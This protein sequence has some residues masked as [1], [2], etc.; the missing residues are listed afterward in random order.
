MTAT[1]TLPLFDAGVNLLD[2]SYVDCLE[3]IISR[4]C[5]NG[6]R[7]MLCISS[8]LT[9]SEQALGLL[10]QYQMPIFAT[11]GVHPHHAK[12]VSQGWQSQLQD[13]LQQPQVKAIGETGLDF[14]RNYSPPEQQVRV[15]EGQ[16]EIAT[17]SHKPLYL[18]ERDAHSQLFEM[19]RT[20]RDHLSG[21][22]LHCFTGDKKALYRYLDL[23]LYIGI[24]GW[25]CDERRGK[26][27]LKLVKDIP[28]DRLILETDAPYL[29]P[30]TLTPKPKSRRNEP[31]F[32]VEIC[33][34]LALTLDQD[35]QQLAA[36][37]SDNACRLFQLQLPS[38][39]QSKDSK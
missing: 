33:Q 35:P 3:Q 31:A 21:A 2:S 27:L 36:Q 1:P 24:T 19:L 14:N 32:L 17:N 34:Q 12:D 29:L 15:F 23:D 16:L 13:L 7:G 4:A 11:A 22:I 28:A 8:D 18:H 30:R 5:E 10:D 26:E 38:S 25:A 20:Y 37:T 9:E 39:P 6:L